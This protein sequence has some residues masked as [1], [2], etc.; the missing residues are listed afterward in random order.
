MGHQLYC[1]LKSNS[2]SFSPD[3]AVSKDHLAV[4]K[5]NEFAKLAVRLLVSEISTRGKFSIAGK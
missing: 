1:Q 3:D 4:R 2:K 5:I